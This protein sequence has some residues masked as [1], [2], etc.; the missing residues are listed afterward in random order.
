VHGVG[1]FVQ[2]VNLALYTIVAIAAVWL[3]RRHREA[4]GL[5]AALSFGLLAFIVDV[6]PILPDHPHGFWEELAIRTLIAGL[7]V[8]PFLL[9]RFAVSLRPPS[10]RLSLVLGGVTVLM[11]LWTFA[12]PDVPGEGESLPASFVAY[13]VAFTLHWTVLTIVVP[14]RLWTAG[15]G[16]ASVPR[17]RMQ[18]L[19]L[20]SAA[21]TL[22]LIIAAAGPGEDS[23]ASLVSGLLATT[24]GVAFLAGLAPPPALRVAWRRP[25]AA[26][27]LALARWKVGPRLAVFCLERMPGGANQG[28]CD[29]GPS[30]PASRR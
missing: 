28:R 8:F 13:V 12:L 14:H 29:S 4:A 19:A 27:V 30:P 10:R 18:L 26:R 6:G 17:R 9:F 7:V 5:W 1:Q 11:V 16:E 3:W 20:A 21:I 22:A 24:S 23:A 15:R 2:Y 25:E